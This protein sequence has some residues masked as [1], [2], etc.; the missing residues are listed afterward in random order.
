MALTQERWIVRKK[1]GQE[2]E[3]HTLAG[4]GPVQALDNAG[5]ML[6]DIEWI[7]P[8]HI[9]VVPDIAA[10]RRGEA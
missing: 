2:F 9:E 10:W 7:R 3:I 6:A 8:P 5:F 4:L 1:D